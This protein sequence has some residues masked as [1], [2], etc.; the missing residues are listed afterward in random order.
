MEA[1]QKGAGCLKPH[2]K[3]LAA[4]GITHGSACLQKRVFSPTPL[5]GRPA[6]QSAEHVRVHTLPVLLPAQ[7]A[8]CRVPCPETG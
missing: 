8:H 6:S 2:S 5:L 1:L 7:L 3:S 4:L